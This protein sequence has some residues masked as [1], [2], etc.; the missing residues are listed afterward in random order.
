MFNNISFVGG[1][2]GV[3]KS[4][5]CREICDTLEFQYLSASDVLNW[6]KFNTDPSNKG[7]SDIQHT[8]D[9]LM[10]GLMKIIVP[11]KKYLLDG[12]FCLLNASNEIIRIPEK[13]FTSIKP[14]ILGIITDDVSKIRKRLEERDGRIWDHNL[15]E[16]MQE[17]E[18]EYATELANKLN[19]KLALN[20][21]EILFT[22]FK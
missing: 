15:L 4:T 17:S 13:T 16:E 6:A 10:E 8:Q 1:I 22:F 11:D 2:H 3:G 20:K 14:T 7:V 9:L 19:L 5:I 21:S 12:H 18:M